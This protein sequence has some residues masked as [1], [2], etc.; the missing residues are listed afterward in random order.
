M[1]VLTYGTFDLFHHGHLR[2]LERARALGSHLTVG[3]STDA[4]NALKGKH[5]VE[6]FQ[7]RV[8]RLEALP[9]VDRVIPER[10]W[11]QKRDDVERLAIDL[12]VMGDD[13][14]GAFD[15]LRPLCEVR[16]LPRTPDIS[17]TRLREALALGSVG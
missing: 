17:S 16:Y 7:T 3:V 10:T 11:T 15:F 9:F 6:S 13:W 1:K 14:A 8:R 2:L 5:C 12:F 4:F